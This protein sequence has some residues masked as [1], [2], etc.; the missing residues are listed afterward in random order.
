MAL[1]VLD[2]GDIYFLHFPKDSCLKRYFLISRESEPSPQFFAGK[3]KQLRFYDSAFFF[4]S[5]TKE[6]ES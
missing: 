1:R 6:S 2:Y 3:L 4:S 5:S